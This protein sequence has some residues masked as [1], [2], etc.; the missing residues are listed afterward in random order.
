VTDRSWS[1]GSLVIYW[2]L[3]RARWVR[4]WMGPKVNGPFLWRLFVW[5]V[6][7]AWLRKDWATPIVLPRQARRRLRRGKD[8]HIG[9]FEHRRRKAVR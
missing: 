5:P 9:G 7:F 6:V 2:T 1:L 4:G 8:V 3:D